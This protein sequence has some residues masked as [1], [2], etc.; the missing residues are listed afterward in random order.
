MRFDSDG[1]YS[2]RPRRK[3]SIRQKKPNISIIRDCGLGL[4]SDMV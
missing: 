4:G 1:P 3:C 2:E